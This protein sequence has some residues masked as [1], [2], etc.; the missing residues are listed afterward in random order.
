MENTDWFAI[1]DGRLFNSLCYTCIYCSIT[2]HNVQMEHWYGIMNKYENI[3]VTVYVQEKHNGRRTAATTG[4]V[5]HPLGQSTSGQQRGHPGMQ[6]VSEDQ[7]KQPGVSHFP[8]SSRIQHQKRCWDLQ[9]L[10]G[11]IPASM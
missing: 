2:M 3:H 8:E 1:G 5:C 7:G 10:S 6:Y 9:A 11:E 4:A